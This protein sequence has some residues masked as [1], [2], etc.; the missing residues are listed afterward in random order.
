[1]K[2]LSDSADGAR[3]FLIILPDSFAVQERVILI[4]G[5]TRAKH[6]F[7]MGCITHYGPDSA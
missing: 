7:T 6:Y 3:G 2:K 1:M 5:Y 4:T